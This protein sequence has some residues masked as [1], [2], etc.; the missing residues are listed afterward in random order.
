MSIAIIFSNRDAKPWADALQAKLPEAKIEVYPDIADPLAVEFILCWKPE[1]EII[2]Q[3]PNLRVIQ[4]A[5]AGADHI[6]TTQTLDESVAVTRIVDDSLT[7]DMWEHLLACVLARIKNFPLYT[8]QQ[9]AGQWK[10]HPYR[11]IRDTKIS[12]LGLG[13]I[14]SFVAERFAGLGFQVKGWSASPKNLHQ[15]Q[16]FSGEESLTAFLQDTDILINLLPLTAATDSL[17]DLQF[18]RRLPKG[19]YLINVGRGEHLVEED[20]ITILEEGHLSGAMLDVFRTEPL[21]PA[22]PFWTNEQITI[23]PHIASLTN[24]DAVAGQIAGNYNNLLAGKPFINTVSK[25]KGY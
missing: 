21:P 23:T 15:V 4:S 19:G 18:L 3:F 1:P 6:L 22:H 12:I 16:S 2:R 14:G 13:N 8:A 11:G 9:Q 17:I 5:G 25:E 20:L 10:A 24:I 7:G